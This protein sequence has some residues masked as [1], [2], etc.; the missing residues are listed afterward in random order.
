MAMQAGDPLRHTIATSR[1]AARSPWT[2][3][4]PDGGCRVKMLGTPTVDPPSKAGPERLTVK[5]WR[6][7]A[8]R[9]LPF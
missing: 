6:T 1:A 5:R 8:Q 7:Q 4:D 3:L 2:T 9:I